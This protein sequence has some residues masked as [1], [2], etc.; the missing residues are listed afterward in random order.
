MF[1]ET[2]PWYVWFDGVAGAALLTV[3]GLVYKRFWGPEK[4]GRLHNAVASGSITGS[5]VAAGENITQTSVVHHHHLSSPSELEAELVVTQPDPVK[6][7]QSLEELPPYDLSYAREKFV[8]LP[9]LWR[10]AF[11]D[12]AKLDNGAWHISGGFGSAIIWFHLSTLP[13]ALKIAHRNTPIWV[14]GTIKRFQFSSIIEL[15]NDPELLKIE[16]EKGTAVTN[17]TGPIV[18]PT[19]D[20]SQH[21]H[22]P[23]ESAKKEQ[24][25]VAPIKRRKLN[26]IGK[27]GRITWL[28]EAGNAFFEPEANGKHK[29]VIAEFRNEPGEFSVITWR[30]VRASIAFYDEEGA[31]IADVGRAAWLDAYGSTVD[32]ASH[33]TRKLIVAVLADKWLSFDGDE[34]K[35]VPPDAKRAKIVLQDDRE[36]CLPFKLDFDLSAGAVGSLISLTPP[37]NR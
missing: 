19:V 29:A 22:Y 13:P 4:K 3:A 16:H 17:S 23:S 10:I 5:Q 20:T 36:F 33:V 31:E 15:D 14:R 6:I 35:P 8:G 28:D 24:P 7:F 2:P 1:I 21:H 26:V 12:A 27:K 37:T 9:V 18:S 34:P 11:A 25:T 30:H 32:F